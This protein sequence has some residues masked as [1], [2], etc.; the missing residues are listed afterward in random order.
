[1]KTKDNTFEDQNLAG[2]S[3]QRLTI[4]DTMF[5]MCNLKG[6]DFGVATLINCTF[7]DCNLE[8]ASFDATTLNNCCFFNCRLSEA[9]F[10][11]AD[12]QNP[13]FYEC[14][15][16]LSFVDATIFNMLADDCFFMGAG[17]EN[18]ELMGAS[19]FSGCNLNGAV[20]SELTAFENLELT[21]CL[22]ND[23]EFHNS[24]DVGNI[25]FKNC[26]LS[27]FMYNGEKKETVAPIYSI[28]PNLNIEPTKDKMPYLY[29][30][31]IEEM[32]KICNV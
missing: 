27:P 24:L 25:K 2:H 16:D 8:S 30:A 26:I 5:S 32:K 7:Y 1:M 9:T 18:T 4:E 15:G 19:A 3:F 17:L 23:V 22:I 20:I 12:L 6:S 29:T 11:L 14:V 10:D 13:Y 28:P 31:D 21:E